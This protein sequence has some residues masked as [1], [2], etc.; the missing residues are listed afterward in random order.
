MSPARPRAPRAGVVVLNY[1]RVDETSACLA[2]LADLDVAAR[3][4]VVDNGSADGSA[5]R[6]AGVPGVE[7]I[8]NDA[9]LGFAAGNNVAIERLLAD[10]LE[11]VWVLNNDTTVDPAALGELLAV[12]DADP[13]VGAVGSVLLDADVADTEAVLTW[14][15]GSLSRWT[16]RT[17]DARRP[18]DRVDYLTAASLLL[19]SAAL[20][21]VGLFDPRYFFTWE[22]V[23]LCARLVAGGW[24]LAVAERSR[25]WHRGG[26]T[27]APLAPRRLEEHAAGL[28][29]Y[30]RTHGPVPWLT[31]LPLLAYYASLAARHRRGELWTA[32]WRGWRRGWG[33]VTG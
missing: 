22:D 10:G 15:G 3:V 2:T 9:N 5:Q 16:G 30:Q 17:R 11:F 32:A 21:E 19:R 13:A 23:D 4:V 8:A 12:A 25:V 27:L 1:Q 20:R 7:L 29:T 6:L 14:G 26:G 31:T 33:A 28:V 18:G 24:R